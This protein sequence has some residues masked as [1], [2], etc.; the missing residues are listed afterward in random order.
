MATDSRVNLESDYANGVHPAI[1]RRLVETN[2]EVT[3]TYCADDYTLSA[4]SKIRQACACPDADVALLVG[5]TQTNALAISSLLRPHEGVIAADT[6]HIATHESG[7]VE[8]TGHKVITLPHAD[9]KIEAACLQAYLT[10]FF[11]DR[12]YEHMTIPGMVYISQPT[13]FGTLYSFEELQRLAEVCR[14]H[15]LLLY[16]DGARLLYGLAAPANTVSL[17]DMARLCDVFYIG[18]TKAGLLCGEALVFS[19]VR[20]PRHFLTSTKRAGALLAKGRLTGVQFDAL[21]T[22]GLWEEVGA[23]AINAADRL[24]AHLELRG[25]EL[26]CANPTNQIFVAADAEWIERLARGIM[27][28]VCGKAEPAGGVERSLIRLV[29]SWSTTDADIAAALQAIDA[30]C[31]V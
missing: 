13:E 15:D 20:A 11:A 6:G 25:L 24:R 10:E 16:A 2:G 17:P 9:G 29:T 12:T 22:G 14:A 1:L 3:A 4:A 30:A 27:F 5:G 8:A 19:R 28:R 7:A 23:A 26:Y 31:E 18:G 21:F